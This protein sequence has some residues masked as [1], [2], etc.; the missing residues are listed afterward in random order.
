MSKKRKKPTPGSDT[1]KIH[2]QF[3]APLS[4]SWEYRRAGIRKP[5]KTAVKATLRI[6]IW[7]DLKRFRK[8]AGG[9]KK[10]RARA[11]AC[12]CGPMDKPE[13]ACYGPVM[14]ELHLVVGRTSAAILAHELVHAVGYLPKR[15]GRPHHKSKLGEVAAYR[16]QRLVETIGQELIAQ[17]FAFQPGAGETKPLKI[18]R[19]A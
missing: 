12:C 19:P 1:V 10:L 6:V 11:L 9:G 18:A 5:D 17:G 15:A 7:S 3:F 16:M 2:Q 4:C 14:A 13:K 8:Y